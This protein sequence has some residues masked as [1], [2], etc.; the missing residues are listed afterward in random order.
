MVV[1]TN[2]IENMLKLWRLKSKNISEKLHVTR[3]AIFQIIYH[4]NTSKRSVLAVG[5]ALGK[6]PAEVLSDWPT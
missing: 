3:K 5:G 2:G 1:K 6:Q 4:K